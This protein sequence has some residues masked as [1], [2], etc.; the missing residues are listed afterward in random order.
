[1][2]AASNPL[3]NSMPSACH[4]PPSSSR[5]S[6]GAAWP[7]RRRRGVAAARSRRRGRRAPAREGVLEPP[8]DHGRPWVVIGYHRRAYLHEGVL[9][10]LGDCVVPVVAAQPRVARARDDLDDARADVED[11]HVEGTAAEVEDHDARVGLL[12]EG[13]RER[14]GLGLAQQLDLL[15]AREHLS[16]RRKAAEG[17]DGRKRPKAAEGAKRRTC[18]PESRHAVSVAR[19]CESSK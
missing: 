9:E 18:R 13:V 14:R 19:R 16:R 17:G 5:G 3:A 4:L 12:V 2:Q 10:P 1:M 6:R 11:G 8:G 7:P 15:Q